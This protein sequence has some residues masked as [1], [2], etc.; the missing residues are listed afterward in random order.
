LT[1]PSEGKKEPNSYVAICE[2]M[3]VSPGSILFISDAEAELIAAEKA[4][5]QVCF[6]QREGNPEQG[7][8]TFDTIHSLSEITI[9]P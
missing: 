6:S 4:G 2:S 1:Q 9:E 8:G 7:T 5:L 3:A